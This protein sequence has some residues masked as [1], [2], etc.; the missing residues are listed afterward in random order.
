VNARFAHETTTR[1]SE[2]PERS[3]DVSL[4]NTRRSAQVKNIY[5]RNL[6]ITTTEEQIRELFSA[7]GTPARVSLVRDRDTDTPRGFAFV[8]MND[9]AEADAAIKAINGMTFGN[10]VLTV[11]EARPKQ[12]DD[13]SDTT[14]RRKRTRESLATRKH[15]QHRF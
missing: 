11:N 13:R 7:Y 1:A 6:D 15:R 4:G 14:E 10:R 5:V 12:I 9:D 3:L 2:Q 8:E